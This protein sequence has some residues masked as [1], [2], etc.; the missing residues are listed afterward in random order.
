[1]MP[2]SRRAEFDSVEAVWDAIAPDVV[3]IDP[4]L[5]TCCVPPI[6]DPAYLESRGYRVTAQFD[7]ARVPIVVY[8]KGDA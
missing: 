7:G 2:P 5:S 3:V 1:M 8:A 6:T 4:N